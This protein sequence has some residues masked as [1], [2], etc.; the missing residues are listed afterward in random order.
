MK[1]P[2]ITITLSS[3][4]FWMVC[5]A[6]VVLLMVLAVL[7][8]YPLMTKEK[9]FRKSIAS[10]SLPVGQ[11]HANLANIPGE[12][13][14]DAHRRRREELTADYR[15]LLDDLRKNDEIFE[16]WFK[17]IYQENSH[18]MVTP[19]YFDQHYKAK[20]GYLKSILKQKVE[21][22]YPST[23][24]EAGISQ[25]SSL[26]A[27]EDLSWESDIDLASPAVLSQ[28]QKRYWIREMVADAVL[29]SGARV[30]RLEDIY[31]P[32]EAATSPPFK[33][34]PYNTNEFVLIRRLKE[35][36]IK[37]SQWHERQIPDSLGETITFGVS[38]QVYYADIP[39]FLSYLLSDAK[40]QIPDVKDDVYAGREVDKPLIFL[41][42][43][44]CSVKGVVPCAGNSPTE[45][46]QVDRTA[47]SD[48]AEMI[49]D[50]L[51]YIRKEYGSKPLRLILTCEALDYDGKAIAKKLKEMEQETAQ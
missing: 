13:G 40:P 33:Y 46:R 39:M 10:R 31:F 24:N 49:K 42:I 25:D 6:A 1:L 30:A 28:L 50:A 32:P 36:N 16:R 19:N 15:A 34:D 8:F 51:E 5:G 9:D 45:E 21:L 23:K 27:S 2:H 41:D 4:A 29:H 11:V 48:K 43:L 14:I 20:R 47:K 26:R 37:D 7:L 12:P 18:N 44:G 38:L 3:R 22:G 17:E 35:K